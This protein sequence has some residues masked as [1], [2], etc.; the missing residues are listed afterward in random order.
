MPVES[1]EKDN[2]TNVCASMNKEANIRLFKSSKET[3]L[4]RQRYI[5]FFSVFIFRIS[6]MTKPI[7]QS[8]V[9][10]AVACSECKFFIPDLSL[11]TVSNNNQLGILPP[12]PCQLKQIPH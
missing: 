9:C 12:K 4:V 5:H 2:M 11:W 10:V 1:P 6:C 3:C 7:H 8:L